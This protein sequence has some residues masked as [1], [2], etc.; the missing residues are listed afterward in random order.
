MGSSFENERGNLLEDLFV[1][2][3]VVRVEERN[4]FV[5]EKGDCSS[6]EIVLDV[7]RFELVLEK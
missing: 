7:E 3:M 1:E 4:V 2:M 5:F 6:L